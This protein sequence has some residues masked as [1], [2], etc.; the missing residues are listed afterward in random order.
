MGK[1]VKWTKEEVD[2]FL[3]HQGSRYIVETIA[4]RIG[5]PENKFLFGSGNY[6]NSVSSS[7]PLLIKQYSSLLENKNKI[8][9]SGFGVGLSWASCIF[10][11][12]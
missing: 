11:K 6:G 1:Q 5:I 2:Y 3:F 8:I 9:A 10:E 7:I 4:K 12:V